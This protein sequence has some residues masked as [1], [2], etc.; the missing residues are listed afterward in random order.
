MGPCRPGQ[1]V[2]SV[3]PQNWARVARTAGRH[4]WALDPG[5]S[6]ARQPV[7]TAG[8]RARARIPRDS[9]STPWAIRLEGDSPG[10]GGRSR[11]HSDMGQVAWESCST[12]R[13]LGHKR[14]LPGISGTPR[15][16]GYIPEL[17][18]TAAR[19]CGPWTQLRVTRDCW[20]NTR[21]L[22]P[23]H[24]SPGRAGPHRGHSDPGRRRRGHLVNSARPWARAHNARDSWST[25]GALG[26]KHKSAG[27]LFNTRSL[28]NGPESPGTV[29][30]SLRA[31]GLW[32]EWP[33]TTGR[34]HG[35]SDMSKSRPG[36][37]GEPG[38]P[39]TQV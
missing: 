17:P 29:G 4:R 3:G 18:G 19:P 24:E 12:P 5:P 22:G 25:P 37:L 13:A 35:P 15:G 31:I 33:R 38:D 14:D 11:R 20:S 16:L 2:D 7:D 21:A 30:L 23:G 34:V 6:H 27:Q 10:R 26:P 8:P 36:W 9:W 28:G 39:Q 1:L 32:P